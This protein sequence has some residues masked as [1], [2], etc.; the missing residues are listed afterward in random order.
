M[1]Q[2][3]T[4]ISRQLKA[5]SDPK[6]LKITDMLSCGEIC[7]CEILDYFQITQPTLSHD[8]RV[9][10]DAGIVTSRRDG[11]NIYY[12]LETDNLRN[13]VQTLD[14]IFTKKENCVCGDI[15]CACK[16]GCGDGEE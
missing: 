4:D 2:V 6:R 5:L 9:L 16:G 12:S 11:K 8:M 13:L 7:A 1:E 10:M 14:Q 3:Y 15:G